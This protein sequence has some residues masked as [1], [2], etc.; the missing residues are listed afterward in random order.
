MNGQM[1]VPA[2]LTQRRRNGDWG[3]RSADGRNFVVPSNLVSGEGKLAPRSGV[4]VVLT[5]AYSGETASVVE[6]HRSETQFA[7]DGSS[8]DLTLDLKQSRVRQTRILVVGRTG[9]GKSSTINSLIGTHVA[10]VGHFEPTTSELHFF[11]GK[12]EGIPIL[13]VDTPGFADTRSDRSNDERYVDLI[14][15]LTGEIDLLLFITG[16]D[17]PRVEKGEHDTMHILAQRLSPEIWDRSIVLLTRSDRVSRKE[18]KAVL[19]GRTAVLRK[20]FGEVIGDKASSIPFV[21]ISNQRTRTPDRKQW[22]GELWVQMLKRIGEHG[23]EAFALASIA[24]LSIEGGAEDGVAAEP[25]AQKR[26]GAIGDPERRIGLA[27]A[28]SPVPVT[29]LPAAPE[30]EPVVTRSVGAG[31]T[32]GLSQIAP[33]PPLSTVLAAADVAVS[34]PQVDLAPVSEL[35][36][37]TWVTTS[38]EVTSPESYVPDTALLWPGNDSVLRSEFVVSGFNVVR[39][40]FDIENASTVI[41]NAGQAQVIGQVVHARAPGLLTSLAAAGSWIWNRVKGFFGWG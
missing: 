13:V 34:R 23:F 32:G 39:T 28:G 7:Q 30:V 9:V 6:I 3:A 20:A 33:L 1:R 12:I 2:S 41:V 38:Q 22:M 8:R 29:R 18:F 5:L 37:P 19:K 27:A 16:L 10:S 36:V 24:R 26:T 17:D 14:T 31:A 15:R 40:D 4:K 11:N 21:S 25:A 35:R